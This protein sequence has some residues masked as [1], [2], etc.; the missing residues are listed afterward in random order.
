MEKEGERGRLRGRKERERD[1]VGE[2]EEIEC[3]FER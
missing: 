3:V 1:G 2:K